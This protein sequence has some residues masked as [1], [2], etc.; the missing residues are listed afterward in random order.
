MAFAAGASTLIAAAYNVSM[1]DVL[2]YLYETYW[3]PESCPESEQ[4][5]RKLSAVGFERE[6][7]DEA[8][9][10]LKGLTLL[11][12][13][14]IEQGHYISAGAPTT[15][16]A[17]QRIYTEHELQCLGVE[18]VNILTALEL[19]GKLSPAIRELLLDRVQRQGYGSHGAI[20]MD[21]LRVMLLTIFWCLDQEPDPL[22]LADLFEDPDAPR[23]YH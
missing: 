6:D 2:M 11:S 3:R 1:I 8:L 13:Q 20:D 19:Q 18:G 23:I 21:D 5:S 15:G 17:A 16:V 22:I 12:A 10:W 7:I 4:L 14:G 9:S